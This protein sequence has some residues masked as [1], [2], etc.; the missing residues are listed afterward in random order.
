MFISMVRTISKSYIHAR[1]HGNDY[2]YLYI[3]LY[4]H[5]E[6]EPEGIG[7]VHASGPN[8]GILH[9]QCSLQ[10]LFG[11]VEYPLVPFC[12]CTYIRRDTSTAGISNHV[13]KGV[14]S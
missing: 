12:P 9:H 11:I 7:Q 2:I 13:R 14:G 8:I 5:K 10:T 3:Y 6:V 1:I 4:S